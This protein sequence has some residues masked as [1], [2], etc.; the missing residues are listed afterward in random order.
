MRHTFLVALPLLATLTVSCDPDWGKD[1]GTLNKVLPRNEII[2]CYRSDS[3]P[4]AIQVEADRITADGEAIYSSYD[5][6][7]G[8]RNSDPLLV[9]RPRM[10]L[11]RDDSGTYSFKPWKQELGS[12]FSYDV[13][14]RDVVSI[15][16]SSADGIGHRFSKVACH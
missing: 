12:S 14:R 10:E 1:A 2:G 7:L 13:D 5:Y 6:G 11:R 3:V 16:V 15:Q 9:V 4:L 8:G